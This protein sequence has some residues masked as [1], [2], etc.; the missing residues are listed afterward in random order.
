VV[1]E[2]D[3][4]YVTL[5]SGN[6]CQGFTNQLDVV[7]VRNVEKPKLVKSYPMF[8]PHGLAKDGSTLI[9]CEGKEGLKFM[10]VRSADNIQQIAALKGMTT[11]DVITLG[12]YALVSAADGLYIVDY[13]TPTAPKIS[14][15]VKIV[16][17]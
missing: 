15:T 14:S 16:K 13:S 4:A 3:Y 11:Y 8:N 17:P 12:G 9:I 1:A 6:E 2:G 5:R 10:D 7:D